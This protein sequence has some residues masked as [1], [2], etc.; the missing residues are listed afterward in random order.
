MAALTAGTSAAGNRGTARSGRVDH[1]AGKRDDV[2]RGQLPQCV[3]RL[4]IARAS[5]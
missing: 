1:V 5:S 4:R 3:G 2:G